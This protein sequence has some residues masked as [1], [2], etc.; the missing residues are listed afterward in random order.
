[1]R[2]H[3]LQSTKLQSY[4]GSGESPVDTALVF[5][6]ASPA[7]GSETVWLPSLLRPLPLPSP[8]PRPRPR[9]LAL[10]AFAASA[11]YRPLGTTNSGPAFVGVVEALRGK[12]W[13]NG[14]R[15][16]QGHEQV[17]CRSDAGVLHLVDAH[18]DEQER[19]Q[20]KQRRVDEQQQEDVLRHDVAGA[21][22]GHDAALLAA[23][24]CQWHERGHP[25]ALQARRAR[26]F[27]RRARLASWLPT[28]W[29][30]TPVCWVRVHLFIF[31][32]VIPAPCSP[33]P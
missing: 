17:A 7:S 33:T 8:L 23:G 2:I 22:D 1:M 28:K 16:R 29:S 32:K 4:N 21:L 26:N 31:L 10:V 15:R 12:V 3:P 30:I 19:R 6:Q 27:L 18:D 9:R 25:R 24:R 13:P 11:R 20:G 14:R 5:N